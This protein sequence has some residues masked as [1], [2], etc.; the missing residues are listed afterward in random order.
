MDVAVLMYDLWEILEVIHLG[1]RD[2]GREHFKLLLHQNLWDV[3]SRMMIESMLLSSSSFHQTTSVVNQS[4]LV[5]KM[6]TWPYH[7]SA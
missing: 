7:E 6:Y 4:I 3:I 1:S 2:G 5:G